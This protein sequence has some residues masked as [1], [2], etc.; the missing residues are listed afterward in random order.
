GGV[1]AYQHAAV[2]AMQPWD[3]YVAKYLGDGLMVYF[4]WPTAHEDAAVRA[5][6]ASLALLAIL[7]PLN[8]THLGPRYGVRVQVRL[9]LHTGMAVVGGLGGGA[10]YEERGLGGGAKHGAPPAWPAR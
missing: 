5:V 3:G 2:T 4:G 8:D 6:H 10:R 9:G 1:R 7:E